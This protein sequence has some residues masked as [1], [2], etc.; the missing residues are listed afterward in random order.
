M[1]V[2]KE[3]N[4]DLKE[5]PTKSTAE[6]RTLLTTTRLALRELRFK[7]AN[8]QLKDVREIRE[9]RQLVAKILTMINSRQDK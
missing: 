4:M 9:T 2:Y 7:D 3:V 5:L 6:L 1:P 8:H